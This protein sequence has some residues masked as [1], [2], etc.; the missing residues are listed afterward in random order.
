MSRG[1]SVGGLFRFQYGWRWDHR[2]KFLLAPKT[3]F[4]FRLEADGRLNKRSR[5]LRRPYPINA[6]ISAIVTRVYALVATMPGYS[7]SICPHPP[8]RTP[9]WGNRSGAYTGTRYAGF[10]GCIPSGAQ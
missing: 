6:R 8:R 3:F 9:L 5:Q 4:D 7:R 10:V 1:A 2:F